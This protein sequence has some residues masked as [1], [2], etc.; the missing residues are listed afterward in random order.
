MKNYEKLMITNGGGRNAGLFSY[1]GQVIGNLHVS[2]SL[3]LQMWVN[4]P[5]S[6]YLEPQRG[7]NCWDYYFKQPYDLKREDI[8]KFSNVDEQEW[9]EGRLDTITPNFTN[10]TVTRARELTLKYIKPV[11]LIQE[12]INSFKK[13]VIET[14]SYGSIHYRG[15]DHHYGTPNGTFPLIPQEI[16]LQYIDQLLTKFD[17]VL[18][19][20]DQQ[21]F[22]DN[23]VNTFGA[24]KIVHY[25]SIRSTNHKAIHYNN[26]GLKYRTGED[27]VIE[28]FLMSDSKYLVRTCSGVTHFSI[29]NGHDS[30]FKFINIDE[31]YYGRKH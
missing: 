9:F 14:S 25:P 31:V 12:K 3:G 17:K 27:V 23:S 28:A 4:V 16:Y 6:P 7:D 15:T 30:E 29:F 5:H 13:E 10:E 19:C 24:N 2:D 11:D 21:D 20:S 1:V 26:N 18:V 8:A 22:I